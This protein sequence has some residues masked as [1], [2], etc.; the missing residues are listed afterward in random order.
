MPVGFPL[1]VAVALFKL[2][3][4]SVEFFYCFSLRYAL[5]ISVWIRYG[6]SNADDLLDA[7]EFVFVVWDELEQFF[8]QC[9]WLNDVITVVLGERVWDRLGF[10]LGVIVRFAF[11]HANRIRHA[12]FIVN[13]FAYAYKF[14]YPFTLW[15]AIY[16]SVRIGH[17][18]FVADD[19]VDS[20]VI[21]DRFN[22]L[23]PLSFKLQ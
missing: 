21:A 19:L 4:D 8:G 15:H 17:S 5:C 1:T 10:L 9:V 12:L 23:L 3:W 2:V 11:C 18:I 6:F 7:L 14:V 13:N 16:E 22:D 20:V